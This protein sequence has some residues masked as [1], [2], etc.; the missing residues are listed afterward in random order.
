MEDARYQR[1]VR[2]SLL[3]RPLLQRVEVLAGDPD[4]NPSVLLE[5]CRRVVLK[6]PHFAPLV[7][8]GL[9]LPVLKLLEEFLLFFVELGHQL[10]PR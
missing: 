10:P 3:E 1:L 4:I 7:G 5:G 6:A 9:P 8:D 2:D